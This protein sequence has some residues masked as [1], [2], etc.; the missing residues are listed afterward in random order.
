MDG[1]DNSSAGGMDNLPPIVP[2][3]LV[4]LLTKRSDAE[5]YYVGLN[6]VQESGNVVRAGV[7]EECVGH[8]AGSNRNS[9]RLPCIPLPLGLT[10]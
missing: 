3:E 1:N 5:K 9:C 2:R 4:A 8:R 6:I 10:P 7:N